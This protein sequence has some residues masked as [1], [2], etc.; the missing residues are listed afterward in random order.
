MMTQFGYRTLYLGGLCAML[1]IMSLVGFLDL[2]HANKDT[3]RWVQ[4]GLLMCWFFTYG[5]LI[6]YTEDTRVTN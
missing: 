1:P 4:A 3:I 6:P 5:M 2:V